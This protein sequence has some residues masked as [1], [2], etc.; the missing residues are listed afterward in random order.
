MTDPAQRGERRGEPRRGSRSAAPSSRIQALHLRIAILPAAAV[1]VIGVAAAAFALT[2]GHPAMTTRVVLIAAAA[3]TVLTLAA[4]VGAASTTSRRVQQALATLRSDSATAQEELRQLAERSRRGEQP[5]L[6]AE[7]GPAPSGDAFLLL[8]SDLQRERYAAAQAV[9]QAAARSSTADHGSDQRVEVFVNLARRMQSLVHRE[10]QLLDDLESQVEDPVL[11]KGLFTVDH[12]ATRMRR[13]SESL[14]VLGGAVSRRQWSRPVTM[15][16]VL[17]AAVAEVEQYSRVKVVPPI[18]GILMGSAV[19]DVIHLVAELIENATKFSAPHTQA[20]L[21]AQ[22]VTAGLV[23]EVEDRGLGMLAADQLRMNELLADP[24]RVNVSELLQDGRIGLFVVATLAR[25]HGIQVQL[26]GNIYGGIQAIV[27][28]PRTL[29]ET[30]PRSREA[31]A[32]LPARS[33]PAPAAGPGRDLSVL[34]EQVWEPR[35]R[36]SGV[37]VSGPPAPAT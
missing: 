37:P 23:I 10:I 15:H 29:I 13:Q 18:E 36:E 7:P 20:L 19:T 1:A 14:A 26:Q 17:R 22:S 35:A 8:L 21:R 25:R 30:P 27:V 11:L 5:A 33:A 3:L 31:D 2:G 4:A 28:L 6:P 24:A 32:E 12:L 9:L 16:E 34:E